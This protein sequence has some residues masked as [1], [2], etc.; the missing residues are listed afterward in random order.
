M[1]FNSFFDLKIKKMD[2]LEVGLV[3]FSCIAFG[4]FLA[5]LI[6]GLITINIWW[7]VAAVIILGI[8]PFYRVYLR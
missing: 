2:W 7:L 8:R 6:P 3:K 1:G 4:I 5:I